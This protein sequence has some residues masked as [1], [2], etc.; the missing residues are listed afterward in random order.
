MEKLIPLISKLQEIFYRTKVPFDVDLPQIV[1]VGG[2]SSGKSSVLESIVGKDFLPRGNNI[3]TRRPISITLIN[4]PSVEKPWG[5]FLHK[6]GEKYFDFTKIRDEIERDT[7]RICG[8]N[9]DI[10]SN[11][12]VLKL[13][14]S[15]FVDLTL[16]DLPGIT[17]VPTGDQPQDIEHKILDLCYTYVYPKSAIIMAVCPA[18]NDLANADALKLARKVDPMGDRTIGVLTKIDLMDEGTSINPIL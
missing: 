10:S 18:N 15:K 8:L 12:I 9:K 16:V 5:E 1:V 6:P 2:Q 3:C 11:K 7:D 4:T 14:S 17:K 13:F